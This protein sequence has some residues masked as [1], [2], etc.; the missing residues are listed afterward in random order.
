LVFIWLTMC[1]ASLVSGG[2]LLFKGMYLY[3]GLLLGL[4]V[5]LLVL[6][7]YFYST[8]N[9]KDKRRFDCELPAYLDCPTGGGHAHHNWDCTPDCTPDCPS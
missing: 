5:I 4:G 6:M 9:S 3:G 1:I 7:V 2:V 8:R